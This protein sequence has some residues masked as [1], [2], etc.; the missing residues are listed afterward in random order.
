M[1][2]GAEHPVTLTSAGNLATFHLEQG[3][4]EEA[5]VM[6]REVLAVQKRVRG[7]EKT[8]TA[9]NN[10]ALSLFRQGKHAEAEAGQWEVLA[11]SQ[12]MLGAGHPDT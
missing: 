9:A 4:Y 6:L 8:L 10:L 2:L 11:L 5:E 3:K 1:V 12:R 7:E